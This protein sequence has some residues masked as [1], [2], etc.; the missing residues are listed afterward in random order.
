[1]TNPLDPSPQRHRATL[2]RL[3]GLSGLG[4]SLRVARRRRMATAL[5]AGAALTLAQPPLGWWWAALPALALLAA[6]WRAGAADARPARRAFAVGWAAGTGFFLSGL[7]WIAEAF[8]V[9]AARHGWMAPFAIAG[10]AAGL[11]LFWGAGFALAARAAGQGATRGGLFAALAL[12][13]AWALAEYARSTVLTGFPWALPSYALSQSPLAQVGSLTGPHGLGFALLLCGLAPGLLRG[14]ARAAAVAAAAGLIALGWVWGAGREG[15]APLAAPDAPVIRLVQ[16]NAPQRDKWRPEMRRMFF[17]RLITLSTPAGAPP[18]LTVWPETAITWLLEREPAL[19]ARIADAAGGA[20]VLTGAQR[21]APGADGTPEWRNAVQ[22]LGPDGAVIAAYD[23]HHLVPF[24]EYLPLG[25]LMAKLGLGALAGG[26]FGAGPGPAL[27]TL[28]GLPPIQP[29]IC[30]ETIF[31]AEILTG[32]DR[33]ALIVQVTN[34][35]WFGASAGPRQHFQQARMRAI[36][37]GAPVA[38]AANTGISAMIDA[39][40]RVVA[41]IGLNRAGMIE[42]PLPPAAPPTLYARTGDL[43]WVALIAALGALGAWAARR[44]GVA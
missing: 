41:A 26:S 25:G 14:R 43:P 6:L 29:Q 42:A 18:A 28:P 15:A 13:G 24:G 9:D 27:M 4:Q 2:S 21:V 34:D 7:W 30:Y 37:Q 17:E 38:R 20:V 39:H 36:E 16:P 3:T 32:A 5:A 10:M 12:A 19:R 11:A 8:F 44:R 1:M 33:P 40:G 35:A 23:K 22:A 31:P